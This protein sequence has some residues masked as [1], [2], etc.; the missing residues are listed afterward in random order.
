MTRDTYIRVFRDNVHSYCLIRGQISG[1]Y[2]LLLHRFY[3]YVRVVERDSLNGG[4][5]LLSR[6]RYYIGY[7]L[8]V[9]SEGILLGHDGV[10]GTPFRRQRR[11]V[12]AALNSYEYV[13]HASKL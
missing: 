4:E 3:V 8:I 6:H 2:V 13:T 7:V 10:T 5:L 12:L 1:R 9:R 11:I